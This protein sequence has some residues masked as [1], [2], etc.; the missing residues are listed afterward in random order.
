[1]S[2]FAFQSRSTFSVRT[3]RP[4]G[5]NRSCIWNGFSGWYDIWGGFGCRWLRTSRWWNVDRKGRRRWNQ[6]GEPSVK[7]KSNFNQNSL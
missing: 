1:V 2:V 3:R 5:P 4:P 6:E 7:R